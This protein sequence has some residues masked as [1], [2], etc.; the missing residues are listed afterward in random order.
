[1]A[2]KHILVTGGSGFLGSALV[3]RLVKE[4][5]KVRVLDN[6]YRSSLRSLET[7]KD[8]LDIVVGDIRD[9]IVV[10][11]AVKN[12]DCVMHLAAI[13]GTENFYNKPELVLDVGVR[14]MLCVLDACR[15]HNVA[16]LIVASSS[17]TYQEAPIIPSDETVPL[18]VPDPL[19]PRYS[20]G[21]S[22]IISELLSINYGRHDF[23]RMMIFRPHNVYGPEMAWEHV[24]PQFIL[25]AIDLIETHPTGPLP[26]KIQGDGSETRAFIHIDDMIDGLI[27]MLNKGEHMNI[28]HVGNP[29]EEHSI[30]TVAEKVVAYF[31]RDI[32][33]LTTPRLAGSPTR[34]CPN[35]DKLKQ[36]GFS[37]KI[38]LD[39][40]M[41]SIADWYIEHAHERN[42][43]KT[44]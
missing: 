25:R 3:L 17:E 1:M 9:P 41:S 37:P 40:G 6:C 11:N 4:G 8:E 22:K 19:N 29:D 21:G 20:Y 43:R 30:K 44:S 32:N 13:N 36:L 5:Y 14:G 34:R 35:I 31:K 16:E 38:S 12:I 27:C 7:I 2:E 39:A 42:L 33:I 26:Y 24:L 28:Y 23:E 10:D 15:K 18:I